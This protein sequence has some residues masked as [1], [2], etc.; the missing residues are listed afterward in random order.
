MKQ[1]LLERYVKLKILGSY[2]ATAA[3]EKERREMCR[4]ANIISTRYPSKG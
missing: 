1:R 4:I 3:F 2:L